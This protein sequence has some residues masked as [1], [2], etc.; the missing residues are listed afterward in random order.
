MQPSPSKKLTK[1]EAL[2]ELWRRGELRFICTEP[3]RQ[4]YDT[5][6]NAD[7]NSI[8]VWLLA[9][10]SGK[11]YLIAILALEQA[12]RSP[13]SVI[14]LVTDTKVHAK[15]ITEKN[16]LELVEQYGCPDDLKP[17][18]KSTEHTYHFRNGSQIQLAGSDGKH[19]EKLRGQK[20]ALVMVDEAGFCSDLREMVLSVLLPTTT[21]TGGRIVLAST[22]PKNMDHDFMSFVE[23]AEKQGNLFK[24]TIYD[25]PLLSKE[26]IENLAE[27]MGGVNSEEFRREFLCE[28]IKSSE[29]SVIPEFTEELIKEIVKQTEK[30]SFYDSYVSMDLGFKDLT[31]VIFGYYDFMKNTIVIEDEIEFNFNKQGSD[32]KEL[33]KQIE[34]TEKKLWQS[35][36]TGELKAP[37]ARVSDIDLIAI[38]EIRSHS[39]GRLSFVPARKDDKESAINNLRVMLTSNRIIINPKCVNLIRHLKNVKWAKNKNTFERSDVNGHYDFVDALV[40]FTRAVSYQKNPYPRGYGNGV[41]PADGFTSSPYSYGNNDPAAVFQKLFS[42]KRK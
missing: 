24:K 13:N 12:L 23:T 21:H 28:F 16:F 10:Q 22:P 40:Y 15:T 27:K 33:T 1:K 29:N 11:S 8:S 19:Y 20:S 4:M 6:Y 35:A 34:S 7:K 41:R 5:F 31:A 32:L 42:S 2:S 26:Q 18:Y 30:P 17:E 9:R 36:I 38:N 37:Q 14:K 25:N 3:Q 39:N